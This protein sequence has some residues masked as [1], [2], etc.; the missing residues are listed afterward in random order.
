MTKVSLPLRKDVPIEQTWNLESIF[1]DIASWQAAY[2]EVE[3]QLSALEGYAGTLG[4]NPKVLLEYFEIATEITILALKVMVY[5]GLDQST[6]MGD[7]ETAARAGQ[8]RSLLARLTAVRSFEVPEL[9]T[10]GFDVLSTWMENMPELEIFRQY[11]HNLARQADH[12]R[13]GEVE[14]ILAMITE[15][16]PYS[17]PPAYASLVNAEL[18]FQPALDSQGHELEIGQSSITA[19]LAHEDRVVRQTAFDHYADGYLQFKN[20]IAGI[21]TQAFQRDSFHATARR[22]PSSLEA[23]LSPNNIPLDV[24]HNLI[25]VFKKNL[26]VWHKYWRVRREAL[27]YDNLRVSDIKAPLTKEKIHIPFEQAVEWICEGMVPL[28]DEYVS[29]MRT[30]CLKDRWIDWA[31]NKGK[32]QG[33]F[34]WGSYGTQPF[35]MMSYADDVFSLSTLAH[36]LGHSM[37]SYYTRM[38]QPFIYGR[39]SLFVAEV[40]SNFNQAMV[41]DYLFRTQKDPAFQLALIEEAMSNFHRYFFIMPTLARWELEMHERIEKGGPT[42][43]KIYTDR[44]AELFM[45]GYGD[46]VKF[47]NDRIGITWAQFGHM[48]M[49]FYVYQYATGISGAHALVDL[50]MENGTIAAEKYLEFLKAGSS[51]YPLDALIAAG[52]DLTNPEPVE[53]AFGVL[54]QIVDR[55]EALLNERI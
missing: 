20:T 47:D 45:E 25:S 13:S 19:L 33:A 34:S 40:A 5:S 16:L 31:R 15:P 32:R 37:H 36:E 23:S 55:L 2:Q 44:C 54:A 26:P 14:E 30:G 42:N 49:N 18:I 21:Q 6:D 4:E 3:N 50:V 52:V 29:V 41:R 7:P 22:Y 39:Y 35:I 24:F 1:P 38:A 28:G 17:T 46:Q 48:Y 27:G 51:A 8:G 12:Y 53:K 43:A 9:L 10:I 11:F